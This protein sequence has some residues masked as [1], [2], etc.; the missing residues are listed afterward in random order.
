MI[1][2]LARPGPSVPPKD[3]PDGADTD[4]VPLSGPAATANHYFFTVSIN[5]QLQ[6]TSY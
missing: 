2:F 5:T 1:L 6:T 3:R 4:P